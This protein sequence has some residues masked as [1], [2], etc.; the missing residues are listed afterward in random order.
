MNDKENSNETFFEIVKR[1]SDTSQQFLSS[2][3][4][5]VTPMLQAIE[6]IDKWLTKNRY[7]FEN[8]AKKAAEI[9]KAYDLSEKEVASILQK[10]KWFITPGMPLRFIGMLIEI[11]KVGKGAYKK[12]N[13]LFVSFFLDNN[14]KEIEIMVLDW[15]AN[16]L[17]KKRIKIIKD[18]LFFVKDNIN[19]GKINVTNVALPTLISQIDG[20]FSDY[21]VLKGVQISDIKGMSYER[22]KNEFDSRKSRVL[23]SRL[24]DLAKEIFRD[25][26]YQQTFRIQDNPFDFNRHKIMHGE[27]ARYGKKVYLVRAF[28]LLDYLFYLK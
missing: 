10:Y 28:L 3:V 8:I 5:E 27:N 1:I 17:F 22:K 15:V 20:I 2:L 11:D 12:I 18:C 23:T 7:I 13:E 16:N 6:K 14:C 21:L 9:A 25:I 24:D 4:E 26:F 19:N